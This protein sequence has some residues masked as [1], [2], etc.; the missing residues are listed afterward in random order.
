MSLPGAQQRILEKIEGGLAA[1][2]PTLASLFVIF[3]RLTR[4]ET[5]PWTETIKAR[6]LVDWLGWAL[7][8]TAC[9]AGRA[10]RMATRPAA[11][12]QALLL[13]PAA[14][15]AVACAVT[16]AAASPGGQRSVPG[17]QP[18]GNELVV[19]GR[20]CRPSLLRAPVFVC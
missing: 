15:I 19:K 16:V 13:L 17:K 7:S 3:A 20:A 14:M 6:P 12:I 1:S 11:R 18:V 2:D 9:L 10:R 8:T 5:M 4:D